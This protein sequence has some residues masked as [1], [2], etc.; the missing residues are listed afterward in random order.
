MVS[1]SPLLVRVVLAG[2]IDKS[3]FRDEFVSKVVVE[4]G[5]EVGILKR[6]VVREGDFIEVVGVDE[7]FSR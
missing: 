5:F 1:L 2:L 6:V 4:K 7:L 3:S